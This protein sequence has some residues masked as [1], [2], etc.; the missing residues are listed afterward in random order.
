MLMKVFKEDFEATGK[1]NMEMGKENF[2][3]LQISWA[4][5]KKSPYKDSLNK[6]SKNLNIGI[7]SNIKFVVLYIKMFTI[8]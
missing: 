3:E 2:M 4:M 6:R 1:C 8:I 5:Q 7:K